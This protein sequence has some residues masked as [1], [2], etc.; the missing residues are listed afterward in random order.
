MAEINVTRNQ[1]AA[2][3]EIHADG[4]LA[5]FAEFRERDGRLIF[6]HTETLPDFQG[7]GMGLMLAKGALADAAGTGATIVPV[8]PFFQRYLRSHDIEGAVVEW[9]PEAEPPA[10]A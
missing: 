2:R 8:C 1:E 5:G 10:E 6:T 4:V 3:Y 9:P 7:Q